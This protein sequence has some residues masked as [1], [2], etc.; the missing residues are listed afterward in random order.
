MNKWFDWFDRFDLNKL[1]NRIRTLFVF[2]VLRFS[3]IFGSWGVCQR[4]ECYGKQ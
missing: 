4:D 1:C 3:V 2:P